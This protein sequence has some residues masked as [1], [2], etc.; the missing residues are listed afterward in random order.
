MN[1]PNLLSGLILHAVQRPCQVKEQEKSSNI[2]QQPSFGDRK[3]SNT[4]SQKRGGGKTTRI[5]IL[6]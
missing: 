3:L 5:I 6:L 2:E 1:R 4:Q